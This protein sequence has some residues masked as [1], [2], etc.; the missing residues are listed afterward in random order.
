[1]GENEFFSNHE[2]P[3]IDL[4]KE[5]I[6]S[7]YFP[8]L[9]RRMEVIPLSNRIL[10]TRIDTLHFIKS[11]RLLKNFFRELAGNFSALIVTAAGVMVPHNKHLIT[12]KFSAHS[13]VA[14]V[15]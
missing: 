9:K 3:L 14:A 8:I 15:S 12:T 7:K 2:R 6:V 4:V 5:I 10:T 13:R 11:L 1:M